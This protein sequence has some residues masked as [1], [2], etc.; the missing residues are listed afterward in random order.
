MSEAP[1][2]SAGHALLVNGDVLQM[3]RMRNSQLS[4]KPIG[5]TGG[6][7]S[8][9]VVVSAAYLVAVMG[10]LMRWRRALLP[11]AVS[12]VV[13]LTTAPVINQSRKKMKSALFIA[14]TV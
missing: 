2:P 3:L 12:H 1:P 4:V 13:C 11:P 5:D 6:C 9:F 10:W 8:G 14:S 7:L